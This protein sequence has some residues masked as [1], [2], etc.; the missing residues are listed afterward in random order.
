VPAQH[1]PLDSGL[2]PAWILLAAIA[3]NDD[4]NMGG[5]PVRRARYGRRY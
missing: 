3:W 2:N 5:R 4:G 1:E